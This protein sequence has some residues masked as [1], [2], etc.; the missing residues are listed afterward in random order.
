MELANR[1]LKWPTLQN[2]QFGEVLRAFTV[3]L[4]AAGDEGFAEFL[5]GDGIDRVEGD[6]EVGL[7]PQTSLNLGHSPQFSRLICHCTATTRW[8]TV[9]T[10]L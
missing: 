8:C 6:P 7:E 4:G 10:F 2:Q 9:S 1:L 3:V 5:E